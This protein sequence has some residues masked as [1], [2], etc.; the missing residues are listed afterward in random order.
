MNNSEN[1]G[2][3]LVL[4][5]AAFSLLVGAVATLWESNWLLLILMVAECA[6][7]LLVWHDR[8]DVSLLSIIGVLG[9][10]AEA[11]FVHFGVW[12]YAN[13]TL[14]GVPVWFPVAFGTCG[15]IG[16]RMA[17][18]LTAL[19]GRWHPSDASIRLG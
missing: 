1:L 11:L 9:S 15:L 10:V 18:T 2:L 7:A 12:T 13:P 4:E 6:L 16:G 14:L 8:Y 3:E 5:I 19:W 17:R